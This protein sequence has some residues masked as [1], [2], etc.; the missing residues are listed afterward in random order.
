M[1]FKINSLHVVKFWN[2]VDN[3]L[4]WFIYCSHT[5]N[6]KKA[7]IKDGVERWIIIIIIIICICKVCPYMPRI[8]CPIQCIYW[9]F[10]S[11]LRRSRFFHHKANKMYKQNVMDCW[12]F[13]FPPFLFPHIQ[14]WYVVDR[15][16][17]DIQLHKIDVW[18]FKFY[19]HFRYLMARLPTNCRRRTSR[20][21]Q[22]KS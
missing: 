14:S 13:C 4:Y 20:N 21:Y 6:C 8:F 19:L 12:K 15:I 10:N 16:L 22:Q 3:K 18:M 17:V 5:G 11:S 9:I 7:K 2:I 1:T